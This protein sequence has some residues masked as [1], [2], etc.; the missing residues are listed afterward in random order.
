MKTQPRRANWPAVIL[1]VLSLLLIAAGFR[2]GE[3]KSYFQKAILICTQ[4]IGLG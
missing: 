4:C 1:V 2:N 3:H